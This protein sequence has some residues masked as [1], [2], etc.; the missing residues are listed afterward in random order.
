MYSA[1]AIVLQ[2]EVRI[3]IA[4]Q[5]KKLKSPKT[6]F[7]SIRRSPNA[8]LRNEPQSTQRTQRSRRE[9]LCLFLRIRRSLDFQ[10]LASD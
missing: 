5:P 1:I 7:K 3:F 2:N 9:F 10:I 8:G 6:D 4:T